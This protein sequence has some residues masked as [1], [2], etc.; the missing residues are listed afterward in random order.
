MGLYWWVF[1][2]FLVSLAVIY[3]LLRNMNIYW[4]VCI[5]GS[6]NLIGWSRLVGLYLMVG[7]HL[8]GYFMVVV[9]RF[10]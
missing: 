5:G 2:F 10:L 6:L 3:N 7:L 9:G 4:W 8:M 1:F